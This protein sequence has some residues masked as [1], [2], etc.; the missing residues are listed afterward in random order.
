M[1]IWSLSRNFELHSS[2]RLAETARARG[3][4]LRELDTT[5]LTAL[6]T[7]DGLRLLS[8]GEALDP[9]DFA[10]FR[11][12]YRRLDFGWD[13][14]LWRHLEAMGV[15]T[16]NSTRAVL[17]CSDKF[18]THQLLRAAGVPTVDAALVTD[19]SQ[20]KRAAEAVGGFPLVLKWVRG[21][22]GVGT[23]LVE[24]M[25]ALR[26]QWQL[27]AVLE[28]NVFLERHHPEAGGSDLRVLVLG[29]SVI[30]CYERR[31]PADDFR[32]NLHRGGSGV[33]H[34]PTDEERELALAAAEALGLDFAGVDLLPTDDGPKVLEV[35]SVPGFRGAEEITGADVAGAVIR[36]IEGRVRGR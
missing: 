29:G 2:R 26:G 33:P 1:L 7:G 3:H 14:A 13:L 20:L 28:Q 8:D 32:S 17:R 4:E 30:A 18:H 16:L 35:N 21:T 36:F 11:S 9:P 27:S 5:R 10:V 22:R 23:A 24:S 34:E 25:K 15:P 19:E 31:A 6:V 12:G